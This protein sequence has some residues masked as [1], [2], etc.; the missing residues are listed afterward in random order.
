MASTQ[1]ECQLSTI[2]SRGGFSQLSVCERDPEFAASIGM[3]TEMPWL[4]IRSDFPCSD[5]KAGS[6]FISQDERMSESHVETLE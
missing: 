4:E 1:E 5:V 6:A 2:T 3:D